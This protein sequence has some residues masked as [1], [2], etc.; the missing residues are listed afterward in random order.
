MEEG[1]V[2]HTAG[3]KGLGTRLLEDGGG[4]SSPSAGNK[5]LGT[6]LLEDGGGE[7]NP[8]CR[9]QRLLKRECHG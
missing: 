4:E 9:Q 2:T 8:Y 5:S 3:N 1:R 7:S 6:R